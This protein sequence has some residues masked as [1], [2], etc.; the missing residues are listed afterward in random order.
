MGER[1]R[2]RE[3]EC[4]VRWGQEIPIGCMVLW[5]VGEDSRDRFLMWKLG[6]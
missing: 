6:V 3:H 2:E 1:E 5:N 4:E